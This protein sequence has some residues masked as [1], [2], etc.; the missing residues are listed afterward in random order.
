MVVRTRWVA[1][2]VSA[3]TLMLALACRNDYGAGPD[4]ETRVLA[5]SATNI[6]GT[7][8]T[9]V[10]DVPTVRLTGRDGKALPNVTIEFLARA[11]EGSVT[12]PTAVTDPDGIAS[13]GAWTLA[14]HAGTN[15]LSVRVAGVERLRFVASVRGGS[16]ASLISQ[17]DEQAGLIGGA[18]VAPTV[19]ALDK[20]NNPATTP[21][22]FAVTEGDGLVLGATAFPDAKG[23]ARPTSWVLGQTPGRNALTASVPGLASVTLVAQALDPATIAWFTLDGILA[24]SKLWQPADFYIYG[25]RLALGNYDPCLCHQQADYFIEEIDWSWPGQSDRHSGRYETDGPGSA[26]IGIRIATEVARVD[27]KT[28]LIDRKD[29][30]FGMPITWVYK[31][32]NGAP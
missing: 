22:T 20:Y 21:V 2:V 31:M 15:V 16:A 19:L 6:E 11:G 27:G 32:T 12:V 24:N 29:L 17:T 26:P 10:A 13:A 9:A 4:A 18:V 25:A 30:D 14:I 1:I 5:L 3:G 23:L 7:V 8:G 28:L